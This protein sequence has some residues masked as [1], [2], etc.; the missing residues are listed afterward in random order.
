MRKFCSIIGALVFAMFLAFGGAVPAQAAVPG[1]ASITC[2]EED[3]CV[4]A[5]VS[6]GGDGYWMARQSNGTTWVRLT[7]VPGW[8]NTYVAPITCK[9]QSSCMLDYAHSCWYAAQQSNGVRTSIWVRL[10]LY[11]GL[12]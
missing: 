11:D 9:Y 4:L 8:N 12:W 3:S 6:N 7:L 10:T 2:V 5:F 1:L